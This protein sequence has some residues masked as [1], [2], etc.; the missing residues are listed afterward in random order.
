MKK[1]E[2]VRVNL[3]CKESEIKILKEKDEKIYSFIFM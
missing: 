2:I 3:N 1:Q